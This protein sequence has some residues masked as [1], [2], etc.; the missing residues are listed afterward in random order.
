MAN[1]SPDVERGLEGRHERG[2]RDPKFRGRPDALLFDLVP[3]PSRSICELIQVD[4]ES[5]AL[6]SGTD[7]SDCQSASFP[8]RPTDSASSSSTLLSGE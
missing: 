7:L 3:L 5:R 8:A 4:P 2:H 6:K 1:A